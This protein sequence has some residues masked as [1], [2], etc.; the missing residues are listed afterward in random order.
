MGSEADRFWGSASEEIAALESST[1][2]VRYL[3]CCEF[4]LQLSRG[5]NYRNVC[6]ELLSQFV[7]AHPTHS[8]AHCTANFESV[9]C[10]W[11]ACLVIPVW[12]VCLEYSPR[13]SVC[14]GLSHWSNLKVWI[15]FCRADFHT[16]PGILVC[17]CLSYVCAFWSFC[18][19]KEQQGDMSRVWINEC[20]FGANLLY[21]QK[22][23]CCLLHIFQIMDGWTT[24]S[25]LT[26]CTWFNSTKV[27]WLYEARAPTLDATA[28]KFC[29][30]SNA[31]QT[32]WISGIAR[33]D[34]VVGCVGGPWQSEH[35]RD[36]NFMGRNVRKNES[37]VYAYHNVQSDFIVRETHSPGRMSCACCDLLRVLRVLRPLYTVMLR[38]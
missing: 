36:K 13:S 10:I 9:C 16:C 1:W 29:M 21:Q 3:F 27:H 4:D 11:T 25:Y 12:L 2:R 5:C 17:C 22:H 37:Y 34:V 30:R 14:K 26:A 15:S 8:M 32:Y 35:H 31:G 23:T 28:A 18:F 24:A 19:M 20:R 6:F 38:N 7:H 33:M